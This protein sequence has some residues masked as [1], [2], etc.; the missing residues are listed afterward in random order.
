MV[1]PKETDRRVF[2]VGW[3]R[4]VTD[5]NRTVTLWTAVRYD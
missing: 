5:E 3:D 4:A 1:S 2:I